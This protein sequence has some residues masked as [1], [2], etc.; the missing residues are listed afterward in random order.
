[1]TTNKYPRG[2]EWRKWD[3]HLH[4]ASSYDYKYKGDDADQKLIDTL[5][6]NGI[7][8]AAI[9]DHFFIDKD[10]INKLRALANAISYDLVI[11]PGVEMRTDKGGSN[12]HPI[13]IFDNNV[14]LDVLTED[15]NSFKR[16]K[17]I[18]KDN[19][20]SIRW[21]FND[22]VEFSDSHNGVI[23]IHAGN[24]KNGIDEQISNVLPVKI[25]TKDEYA[26]TVNI[27]EIGKLEDID[28]YK[29][30]KFPR[31]GIKPM[32]M[33]SDNHNPSKYPNDHN[34]NLFTW[35]KADPTF[36]GLKQILYE[37]ESR[38]RIQEENP[39]Y[40]IEKSPFTNI[41]ISEQTKVFSEEDDI[42][43]DAI[44]LPLNNN[45][46]SI[47]GGRGT[48]KSQLINYLAAAFNRNVHI[49]KYNLESTVKIARKT[50]LLE[51]E[52]VFDVSTEPNAPFIYIA[53]SQ[54]KELVEKK[55]RFSKN[56]L[57]TIGVNDT[58]KQDAEYVKL[59]D[60]MVN[61]YYRIIKVLYGDGK[62]TQEQKNEITKEI[63]RYEDFIQSITSEQNKKKLET[64]KIR[65]DELNKI[66]SRQT[67][68]AQQY[69]K[70]EAFVE[71][72]N[73]T[74][75]VWNE[76]LKELGVSVPLIDIQ[77]TQK[78][79]KEVLLPK[80]Q[81]RQKEI[82]SAI[83]TTRNEFK[84]YKGDL[85]ALLSNVSSYQN[86]LSE[87]QKEKEQ[88][89]AEEKRYKIIATETF[90]KLGDKIVV[91][92]DNYKTLIDEK[93]NDFK[94]V[95]SL[96]P[97]KKELLDIIL[98]DDLKVEAEV[99]FDKDK[100][101][102]L[103]ID[104][105]DGRS[106]S[107]EKLQNII[108][109]NTMADYFDFICQK[110]EVHT[111]SEGKIREDLRRQ[112]LYV[113]FK[114]FTD[115]ISVGVKVLLNGKPITKLSYGQQ[116]TIYLRLQLA[117]NLYSETIIYD[118]PEDDLDN[119]FISDELISIFK[120]LKKYR[121]II[122][123]SHNANLVVNSDSEQVIVAKNTDG[124]LSYSSGSLEDPFINSEV[125]R[126]LEGGKKAFEDRERKYRLS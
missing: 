118:Q 101:Y 21:D 97:S 115:F 49:G 121:Q 62:N 99:I 112:L 40:E 38:V 46:V 65:V 31:I 1:M 43:F 53:Q 87:L 64:Y 94:G 106:Y 27:L 77:P 102:S 79:I 36:E 48:G 113:L 45:L 17:A 61:E 82:E 6:I 3:L 8:V 59:V 104:R 75:K 105:L 123:V 88:I 72:T 51:E 116:G 98:K 108:G 120:T 9:T 19:N 4:T 76:K 11:F 32:I 42:F 92:I 28:E 125:C 86:K 37:P 100:L 85:S 110:R 54:I 93:W 52:K 122:I 7:A 69:E 20:D 25:A 22:I 66:I 67:K 15:F 89:E 33:G 30:Y 107:I 57:E 124:I 56:I 117:A 84:D 14:D 41:T 83:Q 50:S 95:S 34:P 90:K 73:K 12:I 5:K 18:D 16:N 29:T 126:V 103:L 114:R 10:R 23:T 109:I 70:N 71:E 68:I 119:E 2:S 60:E 47:I 13:I 63:K 44:E 74:I 24:K 96:N 80:L 78:Y 39:E 111:F 26:Q 81:V 55:E 91:S 58:Y 35:I